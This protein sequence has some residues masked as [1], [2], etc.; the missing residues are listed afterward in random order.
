MPFR[1]RMKSF[2][3]K[4]FSR[5]FSSVLVLF[6]VGCSGGENI[7]VKPVLSVEEVWAEVVRVDLN[8]SEVTVVLKAIGANVAKFGLVVGQ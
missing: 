3:K 6:L 2:T 4:L 1:H 7:E 8:A 5:C